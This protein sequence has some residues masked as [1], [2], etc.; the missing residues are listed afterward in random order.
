MNSSVVSKMEDLIKTIR[1]INGSQRDAASQGKRTGEFLLFWKL[2]VLNV[3]TKLVYTPINAFGVVIMHYEY[4]VSHHSCFRIRTL[5][6]RHERQKHLDLA[7]ML[8]D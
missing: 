2:S 7:L 1:N 3:L 5:I 6:I 4:S 8:Y